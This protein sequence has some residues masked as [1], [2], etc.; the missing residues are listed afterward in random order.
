[1]DKILE[2][3]V[4]CRSEVT[5]EKARFSSLLRLH[6]T[7]DEASEW[8]GTE[9]KRIHVHAQSTREFSHTT[10]WQQKSDD[11]TREV[12]ILKPRDAQS[13]ASLMLKRELG[14]VRRGLRSLKTGQH[15]NKR[16]NTT[17]EMTVDDRIRH[18]RHGQ[19]TNDPRCE[20]CLKAPG[21]STHPRKAVADALNTQQS[22]TLL[23][24]LSLSTR[25]A[26]SCTHFVEAR[27]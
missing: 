19:A 18:E 26:W 9:N 21:V 12:C 25:C 1:M 14:N 10:E 5:L 27:S 20:T 8:Y 17:R 3:W 13:V 22:R 16:A 6:E 24:V 11:M 4:K 23:A 15:E 2:P 7:R